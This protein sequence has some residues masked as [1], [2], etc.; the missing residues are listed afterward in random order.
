MGRSLHHSPRARPR[1]DGLSSGLHRDL[2]SPQNHQKCRPAK[3]CCDSA[4]GG[5]CA[6]RAKR[7]ARD[8]ITTDEH[9]CSSNHRERKHATL[10][11]ADE[12]TYGVRHNEADK[13]DEPRQ[14]N[15]GADDCGRGDEDATL[16]GPYINTKGRRGLV[17]KREH[18]EMTCVVQQ[19]SAADADVHSGAEQRGGIGQINKA[20]EPSQKMLRA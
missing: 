20:H 4:N 9:R 5:L 7:K 13:P 15:N 19:H 18:V 14:R 1:D 3:K 17:S 16:Q 12:P 8:E 11:G 10:I 6:K 2:A